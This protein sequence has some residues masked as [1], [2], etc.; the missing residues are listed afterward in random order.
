MALVYNETTGNFDDIQ[1]PPI[2]R[3]CRLQESVPFFQGDSATLT[4]QI[5]GANHIFIDEE[6]QIGNSLKITLDSVGAKQFKVKATNSDGTAERVVTLEVLPCPEFEIHPSAT[7]LHKGRNENVVF[8]W[9]I[10][11]A[12]DIKLISSN[13]TKKITNLGAA[14][15][16]P[17][18]DTQFTFEAKGLE[19][20]RVFRHIIPIKIR[21]AARIDFK[22]N[23]QFSYPNLPV[24]LSWNVENCIAV[25]IDDFGEQPSQG[26]LEVTPGVDTTY[27]IRVKDAF[28]EVRRTVTVRMLPL[29]VVKQ[30]LVPTPQIDKSFD[31]SYATPQFNT[32]ISVPTFKS[33]LVK[34]DLPHVPQLK[35]SFFVR[36]ISSEKEKRIKNPFKSL[37][38]YF[39]RK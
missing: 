29:P 26:Q 16:T 21:E 34:L 4:W 37:Y 32:N 17:I 25:S 19:G 11:N 6:E 9:I 38:A 5:D 28:G 24:I 23:R 14:T 20:S 22:V 36:S 15:F 18:N 39:F 7:V 12:R 27:V 30:I 2:I 8:R 35:D 33:S 13:E 3:Y 1:A 31:I 10:N